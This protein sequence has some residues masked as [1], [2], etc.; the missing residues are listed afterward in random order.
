VRIVQSIVAQCACNRALG[1]RRRE[2]HRADHL[3]EPRPSLV[4]TPIEVV[5]LL[6]SGIAL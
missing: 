1:A 5:M 3:T 2:F 4:K 6:A